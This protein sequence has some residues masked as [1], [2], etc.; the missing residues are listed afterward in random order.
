MKKLSKTK[1]IISLISVMILFLIAVSMGVYVYAEENEVKSGT[2]GDNAAWTLENGTLTISGSGAMEDYSSTSPVPWDSYRNT[3]QNIII[4]NG[5]TNI[6]KNAFSYSGIRTIDLPESI[7]NIGSF[8]FYYCHFLYQITIPDKVE[9]IGNYAFC[10]CRIK[11]ITIPKSVT[12]IEVS[13]FTC[14]S[15]L[16]SI[17]V[18]IDNDYYCSENDILFN[19][20][21]TIL[22]CYPA[23]KAQTYYAIPN[24]VEELYYSFN[25][26]TLLEKIFIPSSVK[27]ISGSSEGFSPFKNCKGT[28]E[29]FCESNE[30]QDRWE[31]YWNYYA[32][33]SKLKV[34]YSSTLDE[35]EFYNS[36]KKGTAIVNIPE[37]IKNIPNS[38]FQDFNNLETVT[39]PKSVKYIGDKIF[40]SCCKM[41]DVNVDIENEYFSSLDG[42][43]YNKD[44]TKII[45]YPADKIGQNLKISDSVLEIGDYAF[46]KCTNL[47]SIEFNNKLEIIGRYAFSQ[48]SNLTSLTIPESV[49][50]IGWCAFSGCSNVSQVYYNAISAK[51]NNAYYPVFSGVGGKTDGV[52][53]IIGSNVKI[54]PSYIFY[55][56]Q[57]IKSLVFTDSDSE[58]K[59]IIG[60][61]SF[62]KCKS[63]ETIEYG[64]G[65][66]GFSDSCF[67]NCTGLEELTIPEGTTYIG[68]YAFSNCD[69]ITKIYYNAVD[70]E[71]SKYPTNFSNISKKNVEVIVGPKVERIRS[72]IFFSYYSGRSEQPL[73]TIINVDFSS[74]NSLKKIDAN[75]FWGFKTTDCV[76]IPKNVEYIG[77]NAF[78]GVKYITY[79]DK[80]TATGS[81]WGALA[82]NPYVEGDLIYYDNHKTIL[83]GCSASA[84]GTVTVPSSV[85]YVGANA[86]SGCSDVTEIKFNGDDIVFSQ[87]ML[88]DI[89]EDSVLETI[90]SPN[91][92]D[93][94]TYTYYVG[95]ASPVQSRSL[96]SNMSVEY[97]GVIYTESNA[98]LF[99]NRSRTADYTV[100]LYITAICENAFANCKNVT[101]TIPDDLTLERI[102]KNAFLNSKQYNSWNKSGAF[103]IGNYI[104]CAAPDIT[105]YTLPSNIICIADSAFE[106]CEKLATFTSAGVLK[107]IGKG[108]FRGCSDLSTISLPASVETIGES[109]FEDTKYYT[110]NS[111]NGDVYIGDCLIKASETTTEITIKDSTTCI[112]SGAFR[113]C[114]KL[115]SISIPSS[116]KKI[117]YNTFEWCINLESVNLG[118]ISSLGSYAFKDCRS[119]ESVSIPASLTK[120][121]NFAFYRCD[122]L[123]AFTVDE[124]N[125]NYSADNGILYNKDK[126]TLVQY[127]AGKSE[128]DS[129]FTIPDG[130]TYLAGRSFCHCNNLKNITVPES[131]KLANYNP[132]E[133]CTAKVNQAD[134]TIQDKCLVSVRADYEGE[135]VIP[136][137]VNEIGAYAFKDCTAIKCIIFTEDVKYI[138][139]G[140][141]KGCTGLTEV[142]LPSSVVSIGAS[143]FEDCE[144][145]EKVAF[146]PE[147]NN[148][149]IQEIG[150]KAF[151]GTKVTFTDDDLKEKFTGSGVTLGEFITCK[152][153]YETKQDDKPTC[154]EK[155]LIVKE[156][157][158]CGTKKS[159]VIPAT[160]HIKGNA[161]IENETFSDCKEAGSYDEVYYCSSC[162]EELERTSK[163]KEI[164]EHATTTREE[165]VIDPACTKEGSYTLVTY[166]SVCNKEISRESITTPA[167]GHTKAEPVKENIKEDKNNSLRTW[168]EVTYCSVCNEKLE[169]VH[170]SESLTVSVAIRNMSKY[171]GQTLE[172]KSSVT[173]YADAEGT[174]PE[175]IHWYVN[176]KEVGTGE[177]YTVSRA[178]GSYTIKAKV[179]V[180][181]NQLA[182]SETETIN[183]KTSIV[184][185]IIAFFQNL[186][187][188]L[189]TYIQK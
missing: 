111:S 47:T 135:F 27:Y 9:H 154:T 152:H 182:K 16:E 114:D 160:G 95:N 38:A 143:A 115:Q 189:P 20:D 37:G 55:N 39:I 29:L 64:S 127:P 120:I 22:I 117:G 69:N 155:G 35:F 148:T 98:V 134:F 94:I 178:T 43:F 41:K 84:E 19:K 179:I 166:C 106:N 124:D 93:G 10:G 102:G 108:A 14:C 112:A 119:L 145:L 150:D 70:S 68:R 140:A 165:N 168:D 76:N 88:A 87:D 180:N 33:G 126:T 162:N 185:I 52:E 104:I 133:S 100:P 96:S 13:A 186:F 78:Y 1:I 7:V 161:V 110:S 83:L 153:N 21:K 82:V 89:G 40:Y 171:N 137:G 86:F 77:T 174:A 17:S 24:T 181:G 147:T 65:K 42:V 139:E 62:S 50:F 116:V 142:N 63:L 15:Y 8:A 129:T 58:H 169:T 59:T 144:N 31:E 118:N 122:E 30:Q 97:D 170:K 156:C 175:N 25:G 3:I 184:A 71:A 107:H 103:S 132:F 85:E 157:T 2:C 113:Y 109:A 4:E 54:I 26:C 28:L 163:T 74:A 49:I 23:K 138:D 187:G 73:S 90:E 67:S 56:S 6:G 51:L 32:A 46:Y 128:E 105:S 36:L 5:I 146:N 149:T 45:Y 176:E 72:G 75:A 81:P 99:C 172:Y 164:G 123:T 141:F 18:D 79:S 53:I 61:D 60:P 57:Y 125:V 173:F 131:V 66:Y 80:M 92:V 11:E 130:V 183:I 48:C 34:V 167:T 158:V 44:K 151:A 121:D 177:S 101:V 136:S 188:K 12:E 159:T 91:T